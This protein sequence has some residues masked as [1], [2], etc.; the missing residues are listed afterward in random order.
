M[1]VILEDDEDEDGEDL[2]SA[3]KFA[4]LLPKPLA[5]GGALLLPGRSRKCGFWVSSVVPDDVAYIVDSNQV[6]YSA[7]THNPTGVAVPVDALLVVINARYEDHIRKAM[8]TWDAKVSPAAVA[9]RIIDA[10]CRKDAS[11]ASRLRW[12]MNQ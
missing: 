6:P 8:A 9:A 3:K 11:L 12:R 7:W 2:T 5:Q 10:E 4:A 1:T